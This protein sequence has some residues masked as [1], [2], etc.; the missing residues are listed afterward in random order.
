[1]TVRL[2]GFE[3]GYG[4][5]GLAILFRGPAMVFVVLVMLSDGP[6]MLFGSPV[7]MFL[8]PVVLF[9]GPVLEFGCPASCLTALLY[10]LGFGYD[11]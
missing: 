10:C 1:M 3:S 7:M 2:S 5:Y 8:S 6:A 4:V 9:G 11:V